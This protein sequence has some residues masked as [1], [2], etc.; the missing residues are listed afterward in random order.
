[1]EFG[2]EAQSL[3]Q[4]AARNQ[5]IPN[6][7]KRVGYPDEGQATVDVFNDKIGPFVGLRIEANSAAENGFDIVDAPIT[8]GPQA[9]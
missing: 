4:E 8:M 9:Q 2:P 5:V 3:S 1:M 6:W 7:L